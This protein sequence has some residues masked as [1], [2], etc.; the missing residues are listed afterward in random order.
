[1]QQPGVPPQMH[2]VP[3]VWGASEGGEI[4]YLQGPSYL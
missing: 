3:G 1:M 2:E 4:L